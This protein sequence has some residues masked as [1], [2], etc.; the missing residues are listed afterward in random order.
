[1]IQ[2]ETMKT[3]L[4]RNSYRMFDGK[5]IGDEELD[6]IIQAGLH[7]PTGMNGQPWHFAV[8][9]NPATLAKL[10]DIR[11]NMRMPGPPPGA[12]PPPGAAPPGPP[13]P[14]GGAP[15]AAPPGPPPP[16]ADP[17]RNAP[18]LILVCGKESHMTNFEDCALATENMM[19]AAWSLGI[20]SGWDHFFVMG[21]FNA[22]E[23]AALKAEMIPEGYVVRSAVF[24]GYPTPPYRDKGP[25]TGTYKFH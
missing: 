4:T 5:P 18:V 15:G 16:Q 7:A 1:M 10:A 20:G 13:P 2:N 3:I 11:K 6:T 22:P 25:R 14:P 24:Y 23:A 17:M 12:T 21:F 9:K 8:I 19:L